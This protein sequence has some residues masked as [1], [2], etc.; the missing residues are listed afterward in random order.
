MG[1]KQATAAIYEFGPF[2]LDVAAGILFRGPSPQHWDSAPLLDRGEV[3]LA[4]GLFPEQ[5]ERFSRRLLLQDDFVA[6][7]RKGHP[8]AG[9]RELSMEK[10][11][12]LSHLVISSVPYDTDFINQALAQQGSRGGLSR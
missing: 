3:D 7:L 12:A 4:I 6:V 8:A 5:G 11:A 2:R 9:A 1:S 10:F